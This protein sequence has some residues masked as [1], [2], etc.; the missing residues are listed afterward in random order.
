MA[1]SAYRTF[2]AGE[3]L[4]A[5]QLNQDIRDNGNIIAAV[6]ITGWT[7]YTPTWT[8]SGTAPSLGNG[9]ASGAYCQLGKLFLASFSVVAG[10]TTTFGSGTYF[11]ALPVTTDT[12]FKPMGTGQCVDSSDSNKE[13]GL[14]PV[15]TA[16]TAVQALLAHATG[17][18][19]LTV[20][21]PVTFA[22]LDTLYRGTVWG[23]VA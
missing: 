6:G 7:A 1:W 23:E 21:N 20:T 18:G 17:I 11:F 13:Y 4:L 14:Y 22:T 16:T 9:T 3:T 8:S 10:S 12:T 2:V 19:N 15:A 5:S